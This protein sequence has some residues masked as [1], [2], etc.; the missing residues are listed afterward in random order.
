[1]HSFLLNYKKRLRRAFFYIDKFCI[2]AKQLVQRSSALPYITILNETPALLDRSIFLCR[3]IVKY[4]VLAA[5]FGILFEES[6]I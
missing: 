3:R 5:M 1:M 2:L 4:L 6:F